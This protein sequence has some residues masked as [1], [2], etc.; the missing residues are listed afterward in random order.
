MMDSFD[1]GEQRRL[2]PLAGDFDHATVKSIVVGQNFS[3]RSLG[4]R[5]VASYVSTGSL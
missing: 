4:D 3:N 1:C 2:I 5:G